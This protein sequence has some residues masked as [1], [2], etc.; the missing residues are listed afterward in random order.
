MG[1]IKFELSDEKIEEILG[2]ALDGKV[3][4]KE[5]IMYLSR[6]C[7]SD[8]NFSIFQVARRICERNFGNKIFLYG[9]I[10][11]STYC[12]NLCTFCYYRSVNE[13]SPRYRKKLEEI[14]EAV[15]RLNRSGI[16]LVDLTMGEDPQIHEAEHY[17]PILDI[18]SEVK[19]TYDLPLMISPGVVPNEIIS[20][21]SEIG[22][23]WYALYQET[24]NRK[25]FAQLRPGQSYDA[26]ATAKV[27]AREKGILVED[28]I[29]LGV[30]ESE[31][32]V[33]NSILEMKKLGAHQVRAMGLEPQKGT[34]F[35]KAH[36]PPILDEMRAIAMM[37]LVHQDR[38][39]PASYD[40]DGLKGLELRIMAGANVITSII[41]PDMGFHGVAQPSLDI[42]SMRRTVEGIKPYLNR[43]GLEPDSRHS[44]RKWVEKEKLL[45]GK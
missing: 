26:R 5:E 43:L 44:Y 31:E 13:D 9:F 25:L 3:P 38:L 2:S 15:D 34:P 32:D 29:L 30:G 36:P 40:V 37:R 8:V 24:H 4:S 6:Q 14:I 21:L 19:R 39:I 27:R 1:K 10:Y 35:E 41:P 7:R 20:K 33:V 28:G 22:V 18:C 17:R 11:F 12:R 23:D 42:D 45:T 16:H